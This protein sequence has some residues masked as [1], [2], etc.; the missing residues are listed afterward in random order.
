MYKTKD[1]ILE[2]KVTEFPISER[3]STGSQCTKQNI[4]HMFISKELEEVRQL[5]WSFLVGSKKVYLLGANVWDDYVFTQTPEFLRNKIG[6]M[7]Y[8]KM[9]K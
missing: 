7:S 8:Y 4:L 1:E 6:L 9:V 3:Y 2:V 5:E